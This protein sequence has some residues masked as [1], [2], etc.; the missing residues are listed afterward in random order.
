M[1]RLI[2]L[3]SLACLALPAASAVAQAPATL[4]VAFGKAKSRAHPRIVLGRRINVRGIVCPFA[5]GQQ[6]HVRFKSHGK[7]LRA[8]DVPVKLPAGGRCGHFRAHAT[9]KR[10]GAIFVR[11]EHVATP[12]LG[13]AS[14]LLRRAHVIAP[15]LRPG[16]RGPTV[17]ALQRQL[18]EA[19]YVVGRRGLYDDRT[20]RAV[21]AFRKLSNL[22]RTSVASPVVFRRLAAGG[23]RF[24]IRH[25]EHGHHVEADLTHQVLALIDHRRVQRLY[26]LSSG[27]PSTPTVLGT[28]HVYSKTPGFNSKG[29]YFSNYFI[30]GYAIHGYHDVP[31]YPA[32]HGCLRVPIPDAVSIY[33]WVRS[34]DAVDVYYRTPGHR[35]PKPRKNAGP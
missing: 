24:S 27:K 22:S 4:D 31:I 5:A 9:A 17:R 20:A 23:G 18:K 15:R 32:S 7:V 26:P 33:S 35:S 14:T 2:I 25:P 3:T 11:A 10:A 1:R 12:E 21:L 16:S 6:V 28:F 34:G 30:R 13:A 19:G 8:V 29:M